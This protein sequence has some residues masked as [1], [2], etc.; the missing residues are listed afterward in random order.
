MNPVHKILSVINRQSILLF[1][2]FF[3]TGGIVNS[4][5]SADLVSN[6]PNAPTGKFVLLG[7]RYR[8][9]NNEHPAKILLISNIETNR[10]IVF[11]PKDSTYIIRNRLETPSDPFGTWDLFCDDLQS[12]DAGTEIINGLECRKTIFNKLSSG[13]EVIRIVQW[14]SV[15]YG[16]TVKLTYN[17]PQ[18]EGFFELTNIIEGQVNEELFEIPSFYKRRRVMR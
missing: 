3:L 1:I 9:E 10:T 17:L 11:N 6:Q 13:E 18:S 14:K 5:L 12:N 8:I 16:I 7:K 15:K 2:L 4:Q